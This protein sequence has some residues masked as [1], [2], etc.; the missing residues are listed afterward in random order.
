MSSQLDHSAIELANLAYYDVNAAQYAES[1]FQIDL[2]HLYEPFLS[3]LTRGARILD[4]GCGGGR[5]LKAFR[6]RGFKPIGIEPS[7]ALAEIAR[8]HSGV[9]VNVTKVEAIEF[10]EE[11]D[12]V[13]ACASLL[14]LPR[15]EL[16]EA[17][18]RIKR[19]LIPDGVFFLSVQS[20]TGEEFLDD[21]RFYTYYTDAAI[22]LSVSS[23]GFDILKSWKTADSS[24]SRARISWS[25]LL[26]KRASSITDGIALSTIL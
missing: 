11:F 16:P 5:D 1:T 6:E 3:L 26:A 24:P 17:L 20:G 12:A 4:V 13:W 2:S 23:I 15:T 22:R 18:R 9:E 10:E 7:I 19:S 8:T 14:H 21:G 25:N